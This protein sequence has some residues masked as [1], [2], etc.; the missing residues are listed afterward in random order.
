MSLINYFPFLEYNEDCEIKCSAKSN[1]L[2]I[3]YYYKVYSIYH[4]SMKLLT[5]SGAKGRGY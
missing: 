5:N 3:Q 4:L 1:E 2:V